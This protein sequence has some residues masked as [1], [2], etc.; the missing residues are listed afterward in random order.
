MSFASKP[1]GT[2]TELYQVVIANVITQH[3]FNKRFFF[4]VQT[5]QSHFLIKKI[6]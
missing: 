3:L 1:T 4:Y 6:M 2:K 5:L